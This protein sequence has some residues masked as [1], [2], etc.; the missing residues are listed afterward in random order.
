MRFIF[1]LHLVL[2]MT[3]F[4]Q[5]PTQYSIGTPTD[6]EQLYLELINRAR[7]NPTAEGIRLA[8][9][10][11]PDVLSNY[12]HFGVNL[13]LMQAEFAAIL[14]QQ[15]LAMNA[16][17]TQAARGHTQ[18]MFEN[19]V[20]QHDGQGGS[21]IVG[22]MT[23]AGYPVDAA[24]EN[25]FSYSTS[26]H[27]GHAGFQV[28]WGPGGTGGMQA[29]RGHRV[30]IHQS[31]FK[32]IG[33]GVLN[34]TNTVNGETV[35]PQLVTQDMGLQNS[36]PA[37]VTGVAYYDLNGNDFYDL[38][39][40]VGGVRVDVAGAS[41]FAIT[42][43]SGGYAVPVPTSNA[44]RNVT[45][46]NLG[47]NHD[48]T[49]AIAGG[50]NV[51]VDMRPTYVPPTVVGPSTASTL[52][53]T[54][55]SFNAVNGATGYDHR[56]LARIAA[57]LDEANNL[58]RVTAVKTGSYSAL[59][60]TVKHASSGSYHLLHPTAVP[61]TLTYQSS[62]YVE[63]NAQVSF[64][65]RLRGATVTQKAAVQVST[66][67][68]NTWT[69][70]YSQVG[71]G[72]PGEGGF[73]LRTASLAAFAGKEIK[74]RF[75]YLFLG[76]SFFPQVG[77]DFG[78]YVDEVSFTN[79]LDLS[80][81]VTT[82]VAGGSTSFDF[83]AP[84]VADYLLWVRPKIS[85]RAWPFGP[86][87]AINA[88][89]QVPLTVDISVQR[90][91][92]GELIDG[93]GT[94][95]FGSV[96]LL[97]TS[98]H[99]FTIINSGSDDLTGLAL[100]IVG[101]PEGDFTA[102]ALSQTTLTQ[103]NNTTFTVTFAPKATGTR[104][105]TLRIASN[106]PDENPFDIALTGT[107]NLNPII[108]DQP[109]PIVRKVGTEA[110]FTVAS[111]AVAPIYQWRKNAV[112]IRGATS[113]E[114]TLPAVKLTD[115]GLYDVIIKDGTFSTTSAGAILGVV[116]DIPKTIFLSANG[117][118]TLTANFAGNGLTTSWR[119]NGAAIPGLAK[120]SDP[121][122]KT[123]T[124]KP[125]AGE[126]S[127]TYTCVIGNGVESVIGATTHLR[128][129]TAKPQ[130]TPDPI[131]FDPAIVGGSYD[132]SIA[133][134][135]ALDLT[136]TGFTATGLPP[137]LK[138]DKTGRITGKPS[139]S[140]PGGYT[141]KVT[142]TNLKG[143]HSASG[144]LVVADLPLNVEGVYAGSIER[145]P[146]NGFLGGRIDLTLIRSGALSGSLTLGTV[147][148]PLTGLL[149]VELNETT[150][151]LITIK[152]PG[153]PN[154]TV[155]F[156]VD[157]VFNRLVNASVTDGVTPTNFEAWRNI[158]HTTN[159]PAN[160]YAAHHTFGLRILT[161][162]P[163]ASDDTVPQGWGYGSF[164][165]TK[166]GK[167]TLAGKLADGENITGGAFVGPSGQI[168]IFQTMYITPLKGSLLGRL[169]LQQNIPND[170]T[171]NRIIAQLS[172]N[173]PA[174]AATNARLY[175]AGFGLAEAV[176][177]EAAG[178]FYT[179]SPLALGLSSGTDNAQLD[180]TDGGIAGVANHPDVTLSIQTGNK[181]TA[182]APNPAGTKLLLTATTGAL[183]GTFTLSDNDPRASF[184]G[185]K[186][187]RAVTYQGIII[188]D[189]LQTFGVGYFLLPRLPNDA[190]GATT[191]TSSAILSGQV[192]FKKNP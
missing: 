36:S 60:T 154:L 17:L 150:T 144:T 24:G 35:G 70:V 102:T 18:F 47:F 16:Q 113:H 160:G 67:N 14:P 71:G 40:G 44:N 132:Y 55:Y 79:V 126:D 101:P 12:T 120:F 172:W 72:H 87:L 134:A 155:T 152:R 89:A 6:E 64:R 158:W 145:S 25:V 173:R 45:F 73:T 142:A 26:V 62:F 92:V 13:T 54:S 135:N 156:K 165:V 187:T 88:T 119:Q 63:S 191:P 34:G 91:P 21:S 85:G 161:G 122:K 179:P 140:K 50:A 66:D 74:L 180:F 95:S 7:A 57:P 121:T 109:D 52:V 125:A 117:T 84:Q 124:I 137:G 104:N 136:P 96:S 82:A 170:T 32:E 100:S 112:A 159:N 157:T 28:D 10:T 107:G 99:T 118:A 176:P 171:D 15:P 162:H 133:F 8:A 116:E 83:T 167:L 39:E 190:P 76:G 90:T 153:K 181:A 51:K 86:A 175:Q 178:G 31:Y 9:I 110:K 183:S 38:G 141:V 33:I 65:S 48:A 98:Q 75:G 115:A 151:A 22:R 27:Q 4:G 114:L 166:D 43:S 56:F 186:V 49:A 130:I 58:N 108:S 68:G 77:D 30:N 177:L 185:K 174:N 163:L 103:G 188:N 169:L 143:S 11:D 46:T 146:L 37:F 78:W 148:H 19:A 61:Q 131:P 2:A 94:T 138:I 164:K 53:A 5:A 139:A 1:L 192:E 59:S 168:L 147:K 123:L 93:S 20:Q 81:A 128:V 97:G 129:I 3:A 105:A 29:G 80:Q 106:D 41:F 182:S 23:A 42:T 189:G 149:D 184:A 111:S 69:D 127:A